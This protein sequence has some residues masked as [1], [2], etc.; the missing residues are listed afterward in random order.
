MDYFI[1]RGEVAFYFSNL[2]LNSSLYDFP[3]GISYSFIEII[4]SST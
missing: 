1:V 2:V 3:I 4:D